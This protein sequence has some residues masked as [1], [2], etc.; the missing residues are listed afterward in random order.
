M[1]KISIATF[2]V[3][4]VRTRL[5]VLQKWLGE[6]PVDVLCLQ[7]TKAV[8]DD[9]PKDDFKAMGYRS[10]YKGEKSYNGVAILTKAPLDG[11]AF[12]FGDGKEPEGETR[13]VRGRIGDFC[14]VNTY[15]PQGK[16]IDHVDYAF[17]HTFLDRMKA[18]FEREYLVSEKIVWVGDMNVAPT[19]IDVTSPEKKREHPCF[20]PDIQQHF[21][22]VKSWGFID[23]FRKFHPEEGHFSF[24]DYRV[25]GALERNI[26]WRIDHVLTTPALE[27]AAVDCFIDR[28]PRGWERP[29]DHT[30]VVAVFDF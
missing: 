27:S 20:A 26:G 18:L 11:F 5:P 10:I 22:D 13:L 16:A 8:D 2:N 9:F 15:V 30:P 29:S 14:F 23:L 4:S 28:E 19:D 1:A 7:E 25:K 3:N 21:E 24:F 6:R 12:G 17:K